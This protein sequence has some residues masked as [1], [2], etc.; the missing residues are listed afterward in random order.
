VFESKFPIN[1]EVKNIS[2]SGLYFNLY[3]L[4][5]G[6]S[7]DKRKEAMRIVIALEEAEFLLKMQFDK[8]LL[9]AKDKEILQRLVSD[10]EAAH[11]PKNSE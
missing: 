11:L 5:P 8:D 2:L 1:S 7:Q 3:Q 10:L 9:S 6:T 4:I